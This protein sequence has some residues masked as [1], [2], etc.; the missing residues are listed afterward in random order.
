MGSSNEL[1]KD[2]DN[3]INLIKFPLFKN[4]NF[5]NYCSIYPFTNENING[6]F[7]KLN[8][9]NKSALSIAGSGDHYLELIMRGASEI[10]TFDINIL[11]K[12]YIELKIAAI[13]ALDYN[14]F[15]TYFVLDNNYYD[16][17]NENIYNNIRKYLNEESTIFW[18][19]LYSKYSGKHIRLS[20][21][22]FKTEETYEFLTKFVSYLNPVGYYKLKNILLNNGNEIN[23][24]KNFR[25]CSISNLLHNYNN[26]FDNIILSNIADFIDEIYK[27]NP[28][29]NFKYLIE[30]ELQYILKE[31]GIICVAYLF[32]SKNNNQN[33][34]PII[35]RQHIIEKYFKDSYDEW[36]IDNSKVKNTTNDS[37]LIYKKQ[38]K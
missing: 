3:A 20:K 11:T 38:I 32:W 6:Y 33:K 5:S 1:N 31:E 12:Y 13:K 22:F 34:V 24:A 10:K 28:I 18:D 23:F 2:I 4:L 9:N 17:F 25:N 19:T 37:I 16:I 36:L 21:L 29:N 27:K 26:C 7:D 15:I 35:N 30:T 8:I 14:D